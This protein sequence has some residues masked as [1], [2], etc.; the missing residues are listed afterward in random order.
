MRVL[1]VGS[2][3]GLLLGLILLTSLTACDG[4]ADDAGQTVRAPAEASAEAA[5]PGDAEADAEPDPVADPEAATN[6]EAEPDPVADPEAAFGDP[7]FRAEPGH[8]VVYS[9]RSQDL[10]GPIIEQFESD[11]GIEVDLRWGDT[12]ELAA[13]LL[14]EG[15]A[16]PADVFLAQDPGGLGAVE[17]LLAP[18]PSA[19]LERVDARFRDADGRWIGLSGRARVIVYNTDRVQPADLPARLEGFTEPEW[20]DRVGWAPGNTSFQTMVTAMRVMQGEAAARSWVE[21]MVANGALPYDNNTA[22]VAAVGAGEV[23]AGLVNHYYLYRFLAEQGETFPARNHFMPGGGPGSLVLVAGAGILKT[24]ARPETAE[25]LLA[26][27]LSSPAQTYFAT[28]TYEYPLASEAAAVTPAGLP[29]LAELEAPGMA[30]SDLADLP[31]SAA[32]LR[33]AGA[34]P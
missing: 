34:L 3:A 29:P 12:A 26:Y 1:R 33:E 14:E 7:N 8:L 28:Q 30:L 11:T 13:T 10:V 9:G 32:L 23:D 4:P 18:L 19:L 6:P 22:V 17:S 2:R 15:D 24:A 5:A 20:K 21:G 16:S 31:G 27:L 25:Q